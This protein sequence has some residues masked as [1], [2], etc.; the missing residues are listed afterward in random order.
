MAGATGHDELARATGFSLIA[1]RNNSL[2]SRG[3]FVVFAF[4]AA[5]SVGI[6]LGFAAV[7]AWPVL[8]FAGA[9]MLV[10][11]LALCHIERH[12]ADFERIVIGGDRVEIEVS[13]GGRAQYHTF[14]RWWTQLVFR[15]NGRELAL[16][17]YGREVCFG[18]HLGSEQRRALAFQLRRELQPSGS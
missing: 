14:S 8:P 6:G 15:E 11:Y 16:R 3:R 2:S 17:C 13:D 7:G 18:R 10:L 9:E 12:A 1:R 5:V 4:I